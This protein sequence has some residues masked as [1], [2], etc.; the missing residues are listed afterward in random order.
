MIL[1]CPECSTKYM[2]KD[3]S[4]GPN[5]RSVRCASCETVWFVEGIDPDVMALKDNQT[6]LLTPET[7]PDSQVDGQVDGQG[8]LLNDLKTDSAGKSLFTA[9]SAAP[10]SVGAHILLRDKADAEKL[11]KR[12]RVIR[13]IW[14]VPLLLLGAAAMFAFVKRQAIVETFPKSAAIYQAL[15]MNVKANGLDI[16][17]LSSQRLVIDGEDVLRVSGDVVNL[18]SSAISAPLVQF[19]LENRSG[20]ALVDWYVEVGTV[21]GSGRVN[22]ETDYPSP[23]IDGVELRYRFEPEDE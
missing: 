12:K 1:T 23:P 14:A 13:L 21:P 10:A 5:G 4:I 11:A 17:N 15:G 19:R 3:G 20:E 8:D 9:A 6:V 2:A 22:I 18:T 16:Q 7:V